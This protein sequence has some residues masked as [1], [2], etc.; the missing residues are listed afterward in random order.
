MVG[1]NKMTFTPQEVE[2]GLH[3]DL[4]NYLIDYGTKGERSYNEIHIT[5]DGYCL[6]VCWEQVPYNH[7]FGGVFVHIADA[8]IVPAYAQFDESLDPKD[9]LSESP[10]EGGAEDEDEE[11]EAE[12]KEWETE[13]EDE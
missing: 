2:E 13:S 5:T 10:R 3:K 9:L 7:D 1:F 11:A 4:L 6:I 12:E 8:S